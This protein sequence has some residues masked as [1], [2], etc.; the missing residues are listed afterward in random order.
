MNHYMKRIKVKFPLRRDNEAD[1]S[2]LSPLSERQALD[3]LFHIFFFI[4]TVIS[5]QT[6]FCAVNVRHF[7]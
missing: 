4:V 7:E 2:S 5:V 3:Q 1:I 6:K